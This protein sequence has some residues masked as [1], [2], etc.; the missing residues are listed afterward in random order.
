MINFDRAFFAE[1]TV[2]TGAM[3]AITRLSMLYT[4]ILAVSLSEISLIFVEEDL[5]FNSNALLLF[6]GAKRTF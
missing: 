5:L 3:F 1:K 6:S 4:G 2:S